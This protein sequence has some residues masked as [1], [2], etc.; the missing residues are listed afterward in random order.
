MD[1]LELLKKDWKKAETEFKHLSDTEIYPM[2]HKKS[3]SIIKT[4]FYID[5]IHYL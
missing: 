3:S 2:L 4:L 5:L 1:E